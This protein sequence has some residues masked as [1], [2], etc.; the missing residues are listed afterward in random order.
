[1]EP[2]GRSSKILVGQTWEN[3]TALLQQ[4]DF[5]FELLSV[6]FHILK[7]VNLL[8]WIKIMILFLKSTLLGYG[9][10]WLPSLVDSVGSLS[11]ARLGNCIWLCVVVSLSSAWFLTV[12]R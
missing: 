11:G 10:T 12:G 3:R 5:L 1:M 6:N 7:T 9:G 4:D 2:N 8:D